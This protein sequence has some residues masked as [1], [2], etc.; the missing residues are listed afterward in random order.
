MTPD[1]VAARL[2]ALVGGVRPALVAIN[3]HSSSGKSTLAA[4]LAEILPDCAVVH[5]DDIA[6]HHSVLG[7]GDLLVSGVLEPVRAGRAVTYRPPPWNERGRPGAIAVPPGLSFLLVEGVGVGRRELAPH[8]DAVIYVDTAAD[9]RAA[10]DAVRVAAGEISPESYENW[11]REEDTH[12]ATERP[13][14][15]ADLVVRGDSVEG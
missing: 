2:V 8:F 10:R 13:E 5:T 1:Q 7:W 14:E 6:W 4:R 11:M 3:G 9:V 15:R 12:F